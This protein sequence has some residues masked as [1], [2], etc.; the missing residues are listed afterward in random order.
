MK[1]QHAMASA[2][3]MFVAVS[4][5]HAQQ[6]PADVCQKNP[7]YR[8][9]D[10]WLGEWEVRNP[11]GQHVGE[12]RVEV[13]LNGCVLL[14]NWKSVRGGEGKSF[15][16]YNAAT[17]NWRQFWVDAFGGVIDYARGRAGEKSLHFEGEQLTAAGERL[18]S[19]MDFTVLDADRVRQRI[20]RSADG[21]KTWA[22]WFEG[23]YHRKK[24]AK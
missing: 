4:M 1:R 16:T 19:R 24:A 5:A 3:L 6:P 2:I 8:A 14:E 18:L 10:F 21:G 23:I 9:F 11:Q 17:K 12:S 22:V 7:A 15:N 13:I 20:E